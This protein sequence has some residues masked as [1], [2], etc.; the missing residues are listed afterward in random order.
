MLS[1]KKNNMFMVQLMAPKSN[2]HDD[3]TRNQYS[4]LQVTKN[5][6]KIMKRT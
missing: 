3:G 2:N 1:E 6:K 5:M 4:F